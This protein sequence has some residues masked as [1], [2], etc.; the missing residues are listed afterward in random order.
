MTPIL[1]IV[2]LAGHCGL[3]DEEFCQKSVRFSVVNV[4]IRALGFAAFDNG[5]SLGRWTKRFSY[6][7][8]LKSLNFSLLYHT[9]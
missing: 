3:R 1:D 5:L 4:N 6:S 7:T 9:D 8:T 2:K